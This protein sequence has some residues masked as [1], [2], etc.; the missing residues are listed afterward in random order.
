MFFTRCISSA[1][2]AA[3]GNLSCVLRKHPGITSI[4]SPEHFEIRPCNQPEITESTSICCAT[5]HLSVDPYLRCML[6]PHHPQLGEYIHAFPLESVM[7]SAGVGI[8]TEAGKDAMFEKGD[9]IH[10]PF[11]GWPWRK[12]V[13]FTQKELIDF[14]ISLVHDPHHPSHSLGVYGIPGLSA[15]FSMIVQ[16]NPQPSDCVVVSGAAGAVGSLAGQLA[17][18]KGC[19]VIGICGGTKCDTLVNEFN[20]DSAI[21]YRS[22]SFEDELQIACPNGIDV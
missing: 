19:R 8:V 22:D 11:L 18:N 2:R 20:F 16:G 12:E 3:A 17:K 14:E 7:S 6:D 21:D 9:I 5:T 13:G 15:Y 4:V 10:A 1:S